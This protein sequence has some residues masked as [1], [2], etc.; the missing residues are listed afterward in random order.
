MLTAL[1]LADYR[2]YR[3][4]AA[5][6]Y[7]KEHGFDTS[8]DALYPDLVFSLDMNGRRAQALQGSEARPCVG[9][10]VMAYRGWRA[11]AGSGDEIFRVYVDKLK[12]LLLWLLEGGR[13]VR[14]L[15]GDQGDEPCVAA[16][17][18]FVDSFGDRWKGAVVAER[19]T[20]VDSLLAEIS[21]VDI[22]VATR[23]HN[24]L[25]STMLGKPV[26]SIGYH[27]KN[28]E[29]MASMGLG[30]YCQRLEAL[31]V[32]LL[33]QQFEAC[34]G[35][36]NE[37]SQQIHARLD[38]LRARLDEQYEKVFGPAVARGQA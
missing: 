37:I 18:E 17:L 25:C 33:Q 16:L 19:I 7:L 4:Q 30:A 3:E 32:E 38:D 8:R 22:V 20:D 2:S 5:V 24:V 11:E 15:V 31:D 34:W 28:D 14:I 23:F 10:G 9:L 36:R 13:T 29:L 26:V 1:R 35:R 27:S 6:N 21:R 12:K